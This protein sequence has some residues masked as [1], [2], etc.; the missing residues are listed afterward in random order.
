MQSAQESKQ[1]LEAA[2]RYAENAISSAK[3]TIETMEFRQEMAK[4][5]SSEQT[6]R[7]AVLESELA[8]V[9]ELLDATT[10]EH[11]DREEAL[12]NQVDDLQNQ[13]DD[14]RASAFEDAKTIEQLNKE[15]QRQ[16]DLGQG[17]YDSMMTLKEE[18]EMLEKNVKYLRDENERLKRDVEFYK[19]AYTELEVANGKG[20]PTMPVIP[21]AV[22]IAIFREG[23]QHGVESACTELEGQ[24]IDFRVEETGYADDFEFSLERRIELD[25][26]LDFD[27][28]REKCGRWS[29]EFVVDALSTLCSDKEFECRIHGVDDEEVLRRDWK[30]KDDEAKDSASA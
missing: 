2:I 18:R 21:K 6:G 22:A 15:V 28:M 30:K 13:V 25:D 9:R 8:G 19:E 4:K 29:E 27:W 20:V 1:E 24:T 26:E 3:K 7:E 17:Y 11:I 12:Q 10:L 5:Q 23:A 14:L 16:Q